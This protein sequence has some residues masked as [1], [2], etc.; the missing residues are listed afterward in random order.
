MRQRQRD[1]PINEFVIYAGARFFEELDKVLEEFMKRPT[2]FQIQEA[3]KKNVCPPDESEVGD[4][5]I[6]RSIRASIKRESDSQLGIILFVGVS[7][8]YGYSFGDISSI[9]SLERK[10]YL[11]KL[12]K[13]K[14]KCKSNDKRFI[15]KVRL[16]KNYL[17]I[18]YG[19]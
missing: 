15:N 1:S 16:V 13:Y 7:H 11:F 14:R 9:A 17:R 4:F 8:D 19:V 18:K 10:E 5:T 2:M 3:I 12:S 6:S